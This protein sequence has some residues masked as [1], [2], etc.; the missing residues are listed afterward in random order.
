M[1]IMLTAPIT[2]QV[3]PVTN[4]GTVSGLITSAA[5]GAPVPFA[6]VALYQVTL[7]GERLTAPARCNAD[8]PYLFPEVQP[9][10]YRVK[11]KGINIPPF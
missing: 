4:A 11:A 2:F 3:D 1:D 7:G 8:G 10:D 6:F 5:T 9:G